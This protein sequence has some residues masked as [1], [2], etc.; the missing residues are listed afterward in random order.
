MLLFTKIVENK[1]VLFKYAQ[2]HGKTRSSK[3]MVTTNVKTTSSVLRK[4]IMIEAGSGSPGCWK[5]FY[6]QNIDD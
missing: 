5:T 6:I 1:A 4:A 2:I 3:E